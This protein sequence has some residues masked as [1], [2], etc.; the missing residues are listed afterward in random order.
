MDLSQGIY[1]TTSQL[2]VDRTKLQLQLRIALNVHLAVG[3]DTQ[4]LEAFTCGKHPYDMRNAFMY[5]TLT[6]VV[7]WSKAFL[8]A[9]PLPTTRLSL[10]LTRKT[11]IERDEARTDSLTMQVTIS[12]VLDTC[13]NSKTMNLLIH[14]FGMA[15]CPF[16]WIKRMK[17]LAHTCTVVLRWK[18]ARPGLE[19][20]VP[21]RDSP[22]FAI[23]DC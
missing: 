11:Q 8:H 2:L 21:E 18:D 15:I 16:G 19:E 22:M 20:R 9:F 10:W 5:E 1:N 3:L 17:L 7:A 12:F 14:G 23:I 4:E 6:R 13:V